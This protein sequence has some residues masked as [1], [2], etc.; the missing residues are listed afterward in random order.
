[1]AFNDVIM[2]KKDTIGWIT[3]N[4]PDR[5]NAVT[6]NLCREVREALV[7][8]DQDKDVRTI[9]ITGAGKSFCAGADLALP[10]DRDGN[11]PLTPYNMF[12]QANL[13]IHS[14]ISIIA[15]TPKPVI[16]A[17]NGGAAGIGMSLG[18]SC[19]LVYLARSAKLNWAYTQRAFVPDGGST[20]HLSQR[21]G[22]P[23]AME[24]ALT[25]RILSA[26]EAFQWGIANA[27]YDDDCFIEKVTE[28]AEKVA[29]GPTW[30]YGQT[31]LLLREAHLRSFESQA[32]IENRLIAESSL[33]ED[34]MEGI[35][36][37]L[38]KRPPKF[39]GK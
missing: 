19:D 18:I 20:L 21:I 10:E 4:R 23:K 39:K 37:F 35:A 36:S 11:I 38:E 24:I 16:S 32:E 13:H 6:V 31:K 34:F 25:G 5:R 15:R 27:V 3:L 30:S 17:M 33:K 1:M 2:E 28:I 8:F 26:E 9:V 22:W 14:A 29:S 12:L 7:L